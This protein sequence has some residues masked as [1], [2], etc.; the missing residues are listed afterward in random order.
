MLRSAP[1]AS[2]RCYPQRPSAPASEPST[3]PSSSSAPRSLPFFHIGGDGG[4]DGAYSFSEGISEKEYAPYP[5][6]LRPHRYGGTGET[7]GQKK[8]EVACLVQALVQGG[9]GG[10]TYKTYEACFE[11]SRNYAHFTR[12][13]TMDDRKNLAAIK[14][15]LSQSIRRTRSTYNAWHDPDRG[16]RHR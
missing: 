14:Y 9:V 6:P 2:R 10:S 16:K 5:P 13:I 1:Y 15:V 3:L 4:G 11:G 12:K 7:G 8:K